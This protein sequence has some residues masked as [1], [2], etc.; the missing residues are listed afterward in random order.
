VI[1]LVTKVASS[2]VPKRD[3][4]SAKKGHKLILGSGNTVNQF[5]QKQRAHKQLIS[6]ERCGIKSM[7]RA[8]EQKNK[9]QQ[10]FSQIKK[11]IIRIAS[12]KKMTT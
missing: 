12:H 10:N 5:L 9:K 7:R 2:K 8:T 6:D 1:F 3:D 4:N 11:T